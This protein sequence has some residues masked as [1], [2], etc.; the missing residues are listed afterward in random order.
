M[1]KFTK[2]NLLAVLVFLAIFSANFYFGYS[3]LKTFSGI[4]EPLWS[5]GRV[6]TFWEKLAKGKL[7]S[8]TI[9][10][11]PGITLALVS[12]VG[13]PFAPENPKKIE[14]LRY[15]P[16]SQA[17]LQKIN[18]LY[19]FLRLPVFL[20]SFLILP[21]FYFFTKRLLSKRT[22]LLGVL[23][24]GTSPILLGI[25]LM[26][27]TDAIA[28]SLLPLTLL[29]FLIYQKENNRKFLYLTGFLLG[30]TLLDKYIANILF[31]FFFGLIFLKYILDDKT[32]LKQVYLK[33]ALIDFGILILITCLTIFVF[34]PAAWIKPKTILDVTILSKA[35]YKTWPAFFAIVGLICLDVFFL[36]NLFCKKLLDF[37]NS[38][39]KWF[40]H[41]IYFASLIFIFFVL[42]NV[43]GSMLFFDFQPFFNSP[44][45]ALAL[46]N[47]RI[48]EFNGIFLSSFYPLLFGL[49][50]IAAIFFLYAIITLAFSKKE[51]SEKIF[52]A[53]IL[54]FILF[55]YL[56]SALCKVSPTVRYQIVLFPLASIIAAVGIEHCLNLK[57]ISK[58]FSDTGFAIL[59]LVI[60]LASLFSLK[61]IDPYFLS[62]ASNFLPK[63]Y[64][65]N[66]RDM[67]D[68]SWQA[69][70]YL[71]SLPDAKNLKV[72][73]DKGGVCEA[74]VGTCSDTL[75]RNK[76]ADVAFDYFVITAGR[77]EKSLHTGVTNSSTLN[78]IA[79]EKL[80]ADSI[81]SQFR[82]NID[83]RSGNYVKVINATALAKS[84]L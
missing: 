15:Q 63:K 65:L 40:V 62:Y 34:F 38:H 75:K 21:L 61:S 72:W 57:K 26:I 60:F 45:P 46:I 76:N 67:G 53:H 74:F 37:F 36:K 47:L 70:Q 31:P 58:Y 18:D 9:C 13:L 68:G 79:I 7:K 77:K 81:E 23:L 54:F 4:D 35:F 50:P 84:V 8:T 17:D 32:S 11:K 43:F 41:G 56:G 80:Y 6:P 27:N 44:S 12:G 16:K 33:K 14:D 52:V 20:F 83:D 42:I 49:A 66:F 71:N 39:K 55:Y 69:A 24:I 59:L 28:W 2:Q 25:S 29:T 73:S 48:G 3:R 30:L 19:F 22:A 64:V 82:I 51:T 1:L 78:D 10:D 5:Y